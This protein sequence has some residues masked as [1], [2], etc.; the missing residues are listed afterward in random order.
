MSFLKTIKSSIYDPSFYSEVVK[1]NENKPFRYYFKL[2]ALLALMFAVVL[3]VKL[4][5]DLKT[6]LRDSKVSIEQNYPKDL[7]VKIEK[8][9][10]TTNA[11]EPYIVK[12]PKN[13]L[14]VNKELQ[15]IEN[16]IVIDTKTPFSLEQFENYKTILLLTKDSMV[17]T[18]EGNKVTITSL[19]DFPNITVNYANI[20]KWLEKTTP[21][22]KALSFSVPFLIFFSVFIAYVFKLLYLFWGALLVFIVG[23][24]KKINLSYKKSYHIALYAV[25][26]PTILSGIAFFTGLKMF[27]F[28]PSILLVIAVWVN[29]KNEE[30]VSIV[31]GVQ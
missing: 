25:T 30:A 7:E 1:G 24:I 9:I 19:K 6:F 26:L 28:L 15:N 21:I 3:S 31:P 18:E 29:L 14:Q 4:V 11:I 8:G 10:A 5:P 23:K 17:S 20:T 2:S 16:L 27:T 13:T 12:F 22:T